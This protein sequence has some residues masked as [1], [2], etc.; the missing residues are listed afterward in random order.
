MLFGEFVSKFCLTQL[1]IKMQPFIPR[2]GG[3][4]KLARKLVAMFPP[5]ETYVEPFIGGGSVFLRKAPVVKEVINDLDKEISQLWKG[6]QS[7]AVKLRKYDFT[8]K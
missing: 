6:M 4:S 1:F 7:S 8:P 3:K 5:H 2:L